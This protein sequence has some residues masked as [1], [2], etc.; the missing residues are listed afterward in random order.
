MAEGPVVVGLG[1]SVGADGD[2]EGVEEV[3]EGEGQHVDIHPP[4]LFPVATH[5]QQH[6]TAVQHTRHHCQ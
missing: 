1:R 3:D 2:A 5:H 6:Y 4:P